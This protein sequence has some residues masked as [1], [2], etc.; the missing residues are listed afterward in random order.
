VL[1]RSLFLFLLLVVFIGMGATV[2]RVV[3][4]RVP[5]EARNT[6]YHDRLLTTAPVII[7]MGLVLLLGLY[8]P[9]PLSAL[10]NDAVH[11]LES[12]P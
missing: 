6:P 5:N 9:A 3:Q 12:Q 8:I 11:F 2:L 10:L 7:L 1:F 4:G